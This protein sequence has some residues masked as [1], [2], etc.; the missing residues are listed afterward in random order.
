MIFLRI[1][2]IIFLI[3]SVFCLVAEIIIYQKSKDDSES[4]IEQAEEVKDFGDA[5]VKNYGQ[6]FN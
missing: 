4:L 5:S 3:S 1:G 2:S 6:K